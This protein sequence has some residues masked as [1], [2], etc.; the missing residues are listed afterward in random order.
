MRKYILRILLTLLLFGIVG[1]GPDC[2]ALDERVHKAWTH[3]Q[4]TK[5]N[6]KR[7]G[8]YD[9]WKIYNAERAYKAAL[10]KRDNNCLRF[11]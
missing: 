11:P 1:C 6:H 4:T 8:L 7:G 10:A 3:L 2:K 5:L 9:R